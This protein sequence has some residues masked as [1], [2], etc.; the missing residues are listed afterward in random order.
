MQVQHHCGERDQLPL[1]ALA[2]QA[3]MWEYRKLTLQTRWNDH[4]AGERLQKF[5]AAEKAKRRELERQRDQQLRAQRQELD[6][7]KFHVEALETV[8]VEA[9]DGE[10]TYDYVAPSHQQRKTEVRDPGEDHIPQDPRLTKFDE[11][12][13]VFDELAAYPN[14]STM[15]SER[16]LPP[17]VAAARPHVLPQ[18][19][20]D[21]LS[22]LDRIT[23]G[24]PMERD[25][26]LQK[27]RDSTREKLLQLHENA[28]ME[29]VM[30]E[31]EVSTKDAAP[32]GAAGMDIAETGE[33][34]IDDARNPADGGDLEAA[35]ARDDHVE[36]DE[37]SL[38]TAAR[39]NAGLPSDE[40]RAELGF[41]REDDKAGV[42]KRTSRTTGKGTKSRLQGRARRP[43]SRAAADATMRSGRAQTST[44][45]RVTTTMVVAPSAGPRKLA[46]RDFFFS[47][48]EITAC[49]K[50]NAT[51][52]LTGDVYMQRTSGGAHQ[53]NSRQL[54][55]ARSPGE[56][57]EDSVEEFKLRLVSNRRNLKGL[58]EDCEM[59]ATTSDNFNY[60]EWRLWPG[61][62]YYPRRD[63]EYR[64]LCWTGFLA[65]AAI[66][67]NRFSTAD[68]IAK[69]AGLRMS[70][71]AY[72]SLF[73]GPA[74]REIRRG[75]ALGQ[76]LHTAI[77]SAAESTDSVVQYVLSKKNASYYK[78][79]H[80][81]LSHADKMRAFLAVCYRS[82]GDSET[83]AA[84]S[85]DEKVE[86]LE[87]QLGSRLLKKWKKKLERA[88]G[89]YGP[90]SW[91]KLP[92]L[93]DKRAILLF[94]NAKCQLQFDAAVAT[95]QARALRKIAL[96][97]SLRVF[98][99]GLKG[100]FEE[101]TGL[102][103]ESLPKDG[104][105]GF[106]LDRYGDFDVD[107]FSR[108]TCWTSAQAVSGGFNTLHDSW[109][110]DAFSQI[111][112]EHGPGIFDLHDHGVSCG[113]SPASS[114]RRGI[115]KTNVEAEA[116]RHL[117]SELV[118][119]NML[120]W[121]FVSRTDRVFFGCNRDDAETS[122]WHG[123][124]VPEHAQNDNW[125]ASQGR[126]AWIAKK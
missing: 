42:L 20:R 119:V 98:G 14:L 74:E 59:L 120:S 75:E 96:T 51:L 45:K 26:Y 48:E 6:P 65:S 5:L 54:H 113:S 117:Y 13:A 110:Q 112:D 60:D 71:P 79:I 22:C 15:L 44:R 84:L 50:A 49:I 29:V 107:A 122:R 97:Q 124:R 62:G 1:A 115:S 40:N 66:A 92:P 78:S 109:E 87:K 17:A 23:K 61:H 104:A 101:A 67:R 8:D 69:D 64:S 33:G 123:R 56:E 72:D 111:A 21:F 100:F 121:L 68:Y 32:E 63:S 90:S 35:D 76:R 81:M 2:E 30:A 7:S 126:A 95:K 77:T 108:T 11:P 4:G 105:A 18:E 47:A 73:V 16:T 102:G 94:G 28:A 46:G 85:C 116:A 99:L 125:A 53:K 114:N 52:P 118:E 39:R 27:A 103:V 9:E 82:G 91:S 83:A 88:T 38:D 12:I 55:W 34:G 3:D 57:R 89:R 43:Q 19:G 24:S 86:M 36:K 41:S 37:H 70:V 10:E 31:I 106:L 80:N 58:V 25:E 93:W